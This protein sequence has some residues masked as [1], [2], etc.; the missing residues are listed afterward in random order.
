MAALDRKD[1]HSL[2]APFQVAARAAVKE[3]MEVLHLSELDSSMHV[4]ERGGGVC[5]SPKIHPPEH[6]CYSFQLVGV[7]QM[8]DV[9][10]LIAKEVRHDVPLR[11]APKI[12][13]V[14]ARQ[15]EY[16]AELRSPLN[17]LSHLGIQHVGLVVIYSSLQ[18]NMRLRTRRNFLCTMSNLGQTCTL[19][20]S[21]T[22]SLTAWTCIVLPLSGSGYQCFM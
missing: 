4:H 20:A 14:S 5:I 13:F 7:I 21:N 16:V 1:T 6:S 11:R 15:A 17:V 3:G 8:F 9:V 18:A 22:D 2:Q 19:P 12:L 10:G